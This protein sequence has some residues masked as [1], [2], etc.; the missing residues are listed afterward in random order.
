MKNTA[1]DHTPEITVKPRLIV[2]DLDGTLLD[3]DKR[4]SSYTME[5]FK[6]ARERGMILSLASGRANQMMT[7]FQEPYLACD[8][9]ISFNGGTVED[10]RQHKVLFQ[11]GMDRASAGRVLAYAAKKQLVLTLYSGDTMYYSQGVETLVNRIAAYER[12]AAECGVDGK[13]N[14]RG[15]AF[16]EYQQVGQATDLIKMVVYEEDPVKIGHLNDWIAITPGLCTEATG[17]GLTGI[18]DQTVSKKTALEWLGN[19][20]GIAKSHICSFGDFDNDIS[21]FEASG[22]SVAVENATERVKSQ[23]THSTLSNNQDGVAHFIET[24]FLNP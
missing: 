18:F 12:L 7:L 2:C 20:L 19:H 21:L 24:Y 6:R 17:Y 3:D 14:A 15:L 5:V 13:I 16:D 23:A 8:F 22:I 10:V 4:I 11:Q 1:T 9:H